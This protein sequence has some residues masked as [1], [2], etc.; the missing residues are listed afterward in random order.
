MKSQVCENIRK[1]RHLRK[2]KNEF[3]IILL[4]LLVR[5]SLKLCFKKVSKSGD[6]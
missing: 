6:F 2:V 5:R 1:C 4:I 3:T